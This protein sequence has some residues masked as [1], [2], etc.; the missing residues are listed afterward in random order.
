MRENVRRDIDRTFDVSKGVYVRES[1]ID[2]LPV[3]VNVV[4]GGSKTELRLGVVRIAARYRCGFVATDF[5]ESI[6][7]I[8]S[9]GNMQYN[10]NEK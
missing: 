1:R 3:Q 4:R 8:R 2:F 5:D 6:N 9:N 10:F 7:E